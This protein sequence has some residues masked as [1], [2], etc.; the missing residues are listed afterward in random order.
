MRW[1]GGAVIERALPDPGVIE[2]DDTAAELNSAAVTVDDLDGLLLPG[3]LAT[4][5]I[6]GHP[7]LRKL[8]QEL[9]A[10]G[11]PIGAIERGPKIL[12]MTGVLGGRTITC[13]PEMRDDV[14]HSIEGVVYQ[15][16]P[17]VKDGNLLTAQGTEEL[18]QFMHSLISSFGDR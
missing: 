14:L 12:L 2:S 10:K 7:G 17:V 3:G 4:W 9:D 5:M 8:I 6:R 11:K 1:A 15:D 13:A 18:P 16:Q